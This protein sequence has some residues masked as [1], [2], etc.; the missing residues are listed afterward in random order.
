MYRGSRLAASFLFLLTG[1]PVAVLALGVLPG[2]VSGS[3]WVLVPVGV[4]F[5]VSHLVALIGLARGA[6]WARTLGVTIAEAGGGISFAAVIAV[7]LGADVGTAEASQAT[8]AALFGWFTAMYA[9]LGVSVGRIQL[10]GWA[11]RSYWWPTP[12]HPAAN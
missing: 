1:A 7:A 5:A 11:R 9:L 12:L 2:R 4:A 10:T 6:A 3:A 8:S